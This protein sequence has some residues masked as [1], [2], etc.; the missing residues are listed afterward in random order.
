MYQV[1][2][3]RQ[4][5]SHDAYGRISQSCWQPI[6]RPR[7]FQRASELREIV[8]KIRPDMVTRSRCI[9]PELFPL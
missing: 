9:A 1:Q 6:G 2:A 8:A 4:T 3:L 5:V 7:T